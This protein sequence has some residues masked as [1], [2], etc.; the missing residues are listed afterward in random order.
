ML[1]EQ[2]REHAESSRQDQEALRQVAEE[3]RQAAEEARH[4]TIASVAAAAEA[5]STS[6]AKMQFL[7]DAWT[8]LRQLRP[9]NPDDVQ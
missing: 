6:L 7:E 8:T 2:H 3:M 4:A 5:L 9:S 1:R